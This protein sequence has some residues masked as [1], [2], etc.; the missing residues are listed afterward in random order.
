REPLLVAHRPPAEARVPTDRFVDEGGQY[1]EEV[2][3]GDCEPAMLL[4][5]P[6][7]GAASAL[8]V[9]A[10]L[11]QLA[12]DQ[13][14]IVVALLRAVAKLAGAVE[15]SR[16]AGHAEA[17]KEREFERARRVERELVAGVEKDDALVVF[18]RV[19]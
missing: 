2:F 17:A 14:G 7:Q 18:D 11:H 6:Q 1:V 3:V 9:I 19:E 13:I 16:D 15:E 5:H 12:D 4:V 10:A 8:A